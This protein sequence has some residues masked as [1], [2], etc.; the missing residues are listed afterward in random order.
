MVVAPSAQSVVRGA[1]LVLLL[2][3]YCVGS[4]SVAIGT[5]MLNLL[6]HRLDVFWVNGG[7]LTPMG[8]V[9]A[10][11]V[12]ALNSYVGNAFVFKYKGVEQRRVV[13]RSTASWY[14][15][16]DDRSKERYPTLW[17]SAVEKTQFESEYL[18]KNGRLWFGYWPKS[19]PKL[20]MWNVSG[21][22]IRGR[23]QPIQVGES[24]F[25]ENAED[26]VPFKQEL[27]VMSTSPKVLLAKDL[28][29][30]EVA[31]EITRLAKSHMK[32]STTGTGSDKRKDFTRTSTQMFI[33]RHVGIVKELYANI[34][35]LLKIDKRTIMRQSEDLQVV[36]YSVGQFYRAHHDWG[37][38]K[39]TRF[40]TVL[41]Y[42]NDQASATAGG[43]TYFAKANGGAELKVHPG[44]GSAVIF[45]NLLEDGSA[46]DNSMHAALPV[47]EGEK[48]VC[49][50]W[51]RDYQDVTIPALMHQEEL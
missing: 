8:S 19:P 47:V 50:V 30:H 25:V 44:K 41:L 10:G 28:I 23:R 11:D 21:T 15:L 43:E 13:V 4:S 49:N 48:Y 1:A 17:R 32:R 51:V 40:V 7:T 22:S 12:K 45:Y 36:H 3:M 20:H 6:E 14:V 46:C 31:D 34:S 16:E 26:G 9:N 29:S 42:L 18:E 27:T 5:E 39:V 38:D 37:K 35:K 2:D 33:P 24:W